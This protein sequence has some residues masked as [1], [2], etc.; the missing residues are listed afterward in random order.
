MALGVSVTRAFLPV[1][2]SLEDVRKHKPTQARMPVLRRNHYRP[3]VVRVCPTGVGDNRRPS[4]T[5][6]ILVVRV[7]PE[8]LVEF[9]VLAQFVAIQLP[10]ETRLA[11]NADRA[12]LIWHQP[13]FN[14]V[15]GQMMVMRVGRER[16]VGKD[17]A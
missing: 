15:V 2:V 11:R 16:E 1:F 3:I 10:P 5:A 6:R 17:R 14:P 8:T 4:R 13:T 7:A 9:A 12:I